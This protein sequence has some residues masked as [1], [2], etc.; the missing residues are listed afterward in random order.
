MRLRFPRLQPAVFVLLVSLTC[1]V[2]V[3]PTSAHPQPLEPLPVL[4]EQTNPS[5]TSSGTVILP[6]GYDANKNYP[7]VFFL[8]ASGTTSAALLERYIMDINGG[9]ALSGPREGHL[10]ALLQRLFPT[11]TH[12]GREFVLVLAAGQGSSKDYSTAD[13]WAKTL[14]RY[15]KQVINDLSSLSKTRKI[16]SSRVV[17]AGFSLGADIAWALALRNPTKLH[18]AIVMS[19]RASYRVPTSTY[20]SL[21]QGKPHFYLTIGSA[22]DTTRIAGARAAVQWLKGIGLSNLYCEITGA[23][24]ASAPPEVFAEALDYVLAKPASPSSSAVP[25]PTKP[26]SKLCRAI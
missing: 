5:S 3:Q 11:G 8:P 4:R 12:A 25:S 26:T 22:E 13:A 1:A 10:A 16:D 19:S 24:H 2:V 23:D 9:A 15:E 14:D 6:P 21:V 17:V 20:P 7:V 18:G